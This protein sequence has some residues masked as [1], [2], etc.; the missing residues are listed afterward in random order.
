MTVKRFRGRWDFYFWF[1]FIGVGIETR[2][3]WEKEALR[4]QHLKGKDITGI[5]IGD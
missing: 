5:T 1:G 4:S 2:V 3:G